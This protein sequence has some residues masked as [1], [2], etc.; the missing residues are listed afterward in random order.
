MSSPSRPSNKLALAKR[1]AAMAKVVVARWSGWMVMPVVIAAGVPTEAE[2]DFSNV[3]L[4]A[5]PAS[6][7]T[8]SRL[9]DSRIAKH[10]LHNPC[11]RPQWLHDVVDCVFLVRIGRL[12]LPELCNA[13]RERHPSACI[14][15]CSGRGTARA[16]LLVQGN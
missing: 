7:R 4:S 11:S 12:A 6:P 13:M 14:D 2:S 5:S 3:R 15:A 9:R 10:R 8:A 1:P 16:L